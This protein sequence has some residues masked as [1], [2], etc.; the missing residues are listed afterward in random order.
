MAPFPALADVD[1]ALQLLSTREGHALVIQLPRVPGSRE[2]RYAQLLTPAPEQP[3]APAQPAPPAVSMPGTD[4]DGRIA[5]LESVVAALQVE[6]DQLRLELRPR[7]A[8]TE[9]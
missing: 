5:A 2:V 1:T 9:G 4:Y 8:P 3:I 7:I 6:V